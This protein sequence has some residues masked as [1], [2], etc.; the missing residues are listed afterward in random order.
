M[1][2]VL[3]LDRIR[4]VQR[5]GVGGVLTDLVACDSDGERAAQQA[6]GV[7]NAIERIAFFLQLADPALDRFGVALPASI[8]GR[9]AL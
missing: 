7:A 3:I 9:R 5:N 1:R 8:F 4:L 2:A 6:K